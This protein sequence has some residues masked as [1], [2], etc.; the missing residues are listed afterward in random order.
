[1]TLGRVAKTIGAQSYEGFLAQCPN[2]A[3]DLQNAE[4]DLRLSGGSEG[5]AVKWVECFAN[6]TT[7]WQGKWNRQ[8]DEK[9]TEI[10]KQ[11]LAETGRAVLNSH[12]GP[13]ARGYTTQPSI[14]GVPQMPDA[15]FQII[16]RHRLRFAVCPAGAR[17]QNRTRDG[18]VC[19]ALLDQGGLH[20][21]TCETGPAR[22]RRHNCIR[23]W[24]AK[25]L[26]ACSDFSASTEQHVPQWGRLNPRTGE[27]E[28]AILDVATRNGAGRLMFIGVRVTCELTSNADRLRSHAH[29]TGS[30]ARDAVNEKRRRYPDTEIPAAS[31]VP[32]CLNVEGALRKKP[33]A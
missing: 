20:A 12:D 23:D 32:S 29:K 22:T 7:K 24:V 16:M 10:V 1:M 28:R 15:H 17:C 2:V 27:I 11:R 8:A 33:P 13:G 31:L 4:R 5:Q 18:R 19:G 9:A 30:A 6:S 21:L 3:T 25:T 14:E 26:T